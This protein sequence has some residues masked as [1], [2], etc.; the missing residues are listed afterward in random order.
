LLKR[1]HAN[2]AAKYCSMACRPN[3][4]P[5]CVTTIASSVKSAA[6]AAASLLLTASSL[7][8]VGRAARGRVRCCRLSRLGLLR[9]GVEIAGCFFHVVCDLGLVERLGLFDFLRQPRR[10]LANVDLTGD[11]VGD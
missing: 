9:C 7:L 11:H 2:P 4:G 10:R 5:V 1:K 6:K 3:I 8:F